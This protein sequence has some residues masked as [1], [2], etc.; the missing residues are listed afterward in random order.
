MRLP[1]GE[2]HPHPLPRKVS[3]ARPTAGCAPSAVD[4][5]GAATTGTPRCTASAGTPNA[6]VSVIPAAHLRTGRHSRGLL[7]VDAVAARWGA[8]PE[9]RGKRAWAQARAA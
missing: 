9:R 8:D 3:T 7:L 4:Q 2:D 1:L 6:T 5:N